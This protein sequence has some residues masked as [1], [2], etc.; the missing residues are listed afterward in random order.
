MATGPP[1]LGLSAQVRNPAIPLL[2]PGKPSILWVCSMADLFVPGRNA[3]T[4]HRVI[5]TVA[6]S[7]HVGLVLSKYTKQL[8]RYFIT[9]PAWMQRHFWLG[10]SAGDQ[11][12]F[13]V[14]W[15]RMLP[16]AEQG[17]LIIISLS[18]LLER[19]VLPS[20]FL[21]LQRCWVLVGGEQFPGDFE[22]DLDWARALRDQCRAAGIP[23]FI[24]QATRGWLPPD[25]W[26]WEFPKW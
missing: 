1:G 10:I 4:I 20:D 11:L 13:D 2:G 8:V 22:M 18:P 6:H 23:I 25:L 21:A 9:Q 7:E 17:W 14:R 3:E 5:M 12:G 15:R 26:I 24:K 16:L 19:V